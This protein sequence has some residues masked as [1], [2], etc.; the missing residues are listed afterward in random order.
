MRRG[1]A[2]ASGGH[3]QRRRDARRGRRRA[4]RRAGRGDRRPARRARQRLRARWPASRSTPRPRA[5][6]IAGGAAR[7]DRPRRGGEPPVH[8]DRLAGLRLRRQPD[9]QRRARRGS[10][11]SST[12]T[13]RCAPWRPG[14]RPRFT[15]EVD[16][17]RARFTGWSV[18]AANSKAYGGGMLRRP[19]RRARRRRARRRAHRRRRAEAPLPAHAAEGLQ[20]RARPRAERERPARR[21]GARRAPT[22]RSPSTPTATRSASCRSPSAPLPGA[23]C[24]SCCRHDRRSTSRSPPRAPP[25]RCRAATGRGGTSLPGKLLMRLEPHAIGRLAARLQHGSAVISAT[26]GKTTTAAMVAGDPRARAARG[27]CTTAPARTWPAAWRPRCWSAARRVTATPGSS[28]STSSGSARS[29][30]SC[31]RARCCSPTSSATSSTATASSTRSPTAGRTWRRARA[32]ALVLNA[33]DPTVADLGRDRRAPI[34]L[35]R[36]GRRDR[37]ARDAARRRRQALPALRRARTATTP[38]TSATSA[39]TTATTAARTRPEPQVAPTTSCWRA[40]AARASRCARRRASGAIALPLPGLYNV[41]NALGAAALALALGATLDDVAAGLHAVSPAFGRA[42]TVRSAARELSILL[43]KN[44]A[45]ANEVLRTLALEHGEHDLLRRAQRQHR[46]RAR[47][48]LGVGRGLRGPR[49]AR[50]ARDVQRHPRRRDGAA[51]EV[52]GRR[53]PSASRSSPTSEP[54]STARCGAGD[55][56]LFALPTYTAMLGAARPARRPRRR[57]RASLA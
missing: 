43:V 52:R 50:A 21:R 39:A 23:R 18:A 1:A 32:A 22:A 16:G 55:G 27:S 57:P 56:R 20:G 45:G 35:R 49:A 51:A 28:R 24:G 26:N 44:P 48:E 9:R 47:R 46:R 42:E 40:C 17:E 41:Y 15:V 33:D 7:R 29:S 4:A 19:R 53:P 11:S 30:T 12:S 25:A 36:R 3:A 34:V 6:C 10:A 31:S 5:T 37:A 13:A 54:A 2:R 14:S 8:R 38:S